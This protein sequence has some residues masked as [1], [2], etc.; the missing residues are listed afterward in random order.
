MV[1]CLRPTG[2]PS[3][4]P[5]PLNKGKAVVSFIPNQG[6]GNNHPLV[7]VTSR[8]DPEVAVERPTIELAVPAKQEATAET[9]IHPQDQDLGIPA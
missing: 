2:Q 3:V 9:L 8:V 5:I 7:E 6:Q 1:R 4:V